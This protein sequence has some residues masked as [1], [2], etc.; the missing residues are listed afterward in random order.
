VTPLVGSTIR[1]GWV[2]V[3]RARSTRSAEHAATEPRHSC[4]RRSR[5][6]RQ[7]CFDAP[8][9][10]PGPSSSAV[11]AAHRSSSSTSSRAALRSAHRRCAGVRHEHNGSAISEPTV[12]FAATRPTSGRLRLALRKAP[13][14]SASPSRSHESIASLRRQRP[15]SIPPGRTASDIAGHPD[16]SIAIAA[17]PDHIG[18]LRSFLHRAYST[19]A[20]TRGGMHIP[21]ADGRHRINLNE[22]RTFCSRTCSS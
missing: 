7:A 11:T 14:T 2:A 18:A 20:D 6:H 1:S 10:K 15:C 3:S 21:A 13:P 8:A 16:L 5:A 19:P 4:R 12:G 22:P 17:R 9:S